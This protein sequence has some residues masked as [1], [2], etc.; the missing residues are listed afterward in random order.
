FRSSSICFGQKSR[1]RD[2]PETKRDDSLLPYHL[3]AMPTLNPNGE[4]ITFAGPFDLARQTRLRRHQETRL[5][6]HPVRSWGTASRLEEACGT[7]C[8][9]RPVKKAASEKSSALKG[10]RSQLALQSLEIRSAAYS[11]VVTFPEGAG[12]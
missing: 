9:P 8:G 4:A 12:A 11:Y 7:Q 5:P 2:Y 3:T 6:V 10:Q 1:L